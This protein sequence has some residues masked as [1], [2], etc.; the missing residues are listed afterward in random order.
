MEIKN[1]YLIFEDKKIKIN[2]IKKEKKNISISIIDNNTIK[3]TASKRTKETLINTLLIKNKNWI[4]KKITSINSLEKSDI[5]YYEGGNIYFMGKK[6][7]ITIEEIDEIYKLKK[8]NI[9]ISSKY[10]I[11]IKSVIEKFYMENANKIIKLRLKYYSNIMELYPE[12]VRI[13]P[14]KTLWGVCYGTNVITYNYKIVC[15]TMEYIDYLVAHEL[16]HIKYKNHSREY[17]DYLEKYI[18]NCKKIRK[19][20]KSNEIYYLI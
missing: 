13:K 2:I 12:K 9:V 16:A 20:L 18:K 1:G 19:E 3:I 6:Y 15:G 17:W 7:K 14:L 8:E 4:I 11:D 10:K 5:G